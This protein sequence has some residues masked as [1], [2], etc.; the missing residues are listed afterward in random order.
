MLF[1]VLGIDALPSNDAATMPIDDDDGVAS[2][3][4]GGT[5]LAVRQSL[6]GSIA[7]PGHQR[8]TDG[9]T[10]RAS[11]LPRRNHGSGSRR[12]CSAK[13]STLPAAAGSATEAAE[14]DQPI[15]P[16]GEGAQALT[17]IVGPTIS[18]S[19]WRAC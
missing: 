15:M 3:E 12:G 18:R 6:R 14:A 1:V 19:R 17:Q 2:G 13:R 16:M 11:R 5:A 10:F 7:P 8:T 4:R 9:C